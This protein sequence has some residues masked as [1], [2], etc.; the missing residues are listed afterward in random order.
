VSVFNFVLQPSLCQVRE[1]PDPSHFCAKAF[2]RAPGCTY[3]RSRGLQNSYRCLLL[4]ALGHVL[5]PGQ[6]H[7]RGG[8][9]GNEVSMSSWRRPGQ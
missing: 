9:Y 5:E 7:S 4:G 1:T 3:H 6:R 8:C 2:N